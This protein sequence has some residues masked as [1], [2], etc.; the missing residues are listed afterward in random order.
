[1]TKSH[2]KGGL[3]LGTAGSSAVLAT[4]LVAFV[5]RSVVRERRLAGA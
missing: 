4:I 3:A 2:D 1:L 5:V